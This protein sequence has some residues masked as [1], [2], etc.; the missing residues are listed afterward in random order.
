MEVD[1]PSLGNFSD[2]L[3][4]WPLWLFIYAVGACVFVTRRHEPPKINGIEAAEDGRRVVSTANMAG[5]PDDTA[6]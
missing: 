1:L 4:L 2:F 5:I 3:A 6:S